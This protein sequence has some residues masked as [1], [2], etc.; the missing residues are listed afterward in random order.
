MEAQTLYSPE[1]NVYYIFYCV[2]LSESGVGAGID[3]YYEYLL[4][5]YIL[6]GE[7]VYLH[8]FQTH[9]EAVNRYVGGPQS[10]EFPF[11]FLDV[12]MHRPAQ[13]ARTFMDALLAFWPGLQVS[14]CIYSYVCSCKS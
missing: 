9:Y 11:L 7:P 10:A 8:R 4:K 5:A 12:H 13:R 2:S 1:G 14:E 6:L 3:S